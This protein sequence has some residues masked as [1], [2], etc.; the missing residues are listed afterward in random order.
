MQPPSQR[1]VL[2]LYAVA[3]KS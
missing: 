1:T 2:E 3:R